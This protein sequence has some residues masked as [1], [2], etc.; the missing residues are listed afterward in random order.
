VH[1]PQR[2]KLIGNIAGSLPTAEG[3]LQPYREVIWKLEFGRWIE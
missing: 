3:S 1:L 2:L